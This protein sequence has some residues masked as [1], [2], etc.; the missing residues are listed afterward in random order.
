MILLL[1][2]TH[3]GREIAEIL[4]A[5]GHPYVLS[6]TTSLGYDLYH[7]TAGNCIIKKFTPEALSTY[8]KAEGIHLIID[9]TH[10]HAEVIKTNARVSALEHDILYWRFE[11][12]TEGT[13]PRNVSISKYTSIS[14]AILS[15]KEIVR[16]DEKLLITGT[17]HIP[18]FLAT[19][20][21]SQ[22]V[23]RIMPGEDSMAI[24]MANGVPIENIIAIKAPCSLEMNRCIF[25]DFNIN[26][27][28]F[29]NSGRGS[30]FK[31]NIEALEDTA[32][33]GVI[34]EPHT[35]IVDTL[36]EDLSSLE[37]ALMIYKPQ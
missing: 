13:L 30:A 37:R 26:Y 18:E 1:G 25:K 29:K 28:V 9:A 32:V 31:S 3:E 20:K 33:K 4:N 23:F 21:K 14:K 8:I 19:F 24:C 5:L 35:V 36:F 17:K 27:F 22:C 34:I 12:K 6:V 7:T 11:R 2:G 16:D 10:P 15:L